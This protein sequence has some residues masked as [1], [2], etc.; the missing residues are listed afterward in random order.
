MISDE[1]DDDETQLTPVAGMSLRSAGDPADWHDALV[2]AKGGDKDKVVVLSLIGN[3][4]PNECAE[5]IYPGQ[6]DFPLVGAE[7]AL[8]LR[9]F[10]E[11]FGRQGFVGDVCAQSYGPFF[12]EAVEIVG[13]TCGRL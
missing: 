1:E 12:D 7:V 9:E 8:R 11:S 10:T 4:A 6:G 2:A 3:E 13:E 5:T